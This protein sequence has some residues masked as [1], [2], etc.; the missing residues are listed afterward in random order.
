MASFYLAGFEVRDANTNELLAGVVATLRNAAGL[1]GPVITDAGG[2]TQFAVPAGV[3]TLHLERAGYLPVNLDV[4]VD[5]DF[6][7]GPVMTPGQA[8][9]APSSPAPTKSGSSPAPSGGGDP[10]PSIDSVIV[11]DPPASTPPPDVPPIQYET[12]DGV[13][14]IRPDYFVPPEFGAGGGPW[15]IGAVIALD[16]IA[17]IFHG[18]HGESTDTKQDRE[19]KTLQN[20]LRELGLNLVNVALS[21]FERDGR[22]LGIE[23][24]IFGK[25]LGP[26]INAIGALIGGLHSRL[27]RWLAPIIKWIARLRDEIRHFYDVW[28][29]PILEVIDAFRKFLRILELFH[30]KWAG[31]LDAQLQALERKLTDPILKLLAWVNEA[32][33]ILDRIITINGAL[34]RFALIKGLIENADEALNVLWNK[35]HRPLTAAKE[36]QYRSAPAVKTVD[37]AAATYRAYVQDGAGVDRARVDEAA[38][39]LRLRLERAGA[40]R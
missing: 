19:I 13:P 14:L 2:R 22:A 27:A 12:V 29:R 5:N 25:V 23:R 15:L 6:W 30:I 39:D 33:D 16:V 37:Q 11:I 38:Q 1:V 26:L 18:G 20:A 10:E 7:I 4:L 35:L 28:L 3:Y 34:Q 36:A 40:L 31:K 24:G 17:T 8:P 32:S 9:P 21:G